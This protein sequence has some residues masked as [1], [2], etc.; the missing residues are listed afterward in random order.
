VLAVRARL[1][2]RLPV[3]SL[4]APTPAAWTEHVLAHFDDF[5]VDHAACERKASATGLSFVVRYPDRKAIIEPLIAFA[6]EELEHFHQ[7]YALLEARGLQLGPDS[8]DNY[9][10]RLRKLARNESDKHLLDRLLIAAIVEAR[11]CERFQLVAEA[12]P[13]G[14]L[15]D[16]YWEITRSESRHHGLFVRLATH[17]FDSEEIRV[18]LDELLESES[19]IMLSLPL[20]AAV[21]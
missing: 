9:V 16:F 3:L 8:K 18:R 20:R 12:L 10:R 17:Y 21:H 1:W 6:Q 7:V 2:Y 14:K 5:L 13:V 15:K 11:G 19:K 4:H